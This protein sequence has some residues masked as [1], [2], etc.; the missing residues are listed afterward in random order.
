MNGTI[1]IP[2]GRRRHQSL[3]NRRPLQ[4]HGPGCRPKVEILPLFAAK[5]L[6]D[7]QNLHQY[8]P[9]Q[10]ND[11]KFQEILIDNGTRV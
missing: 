9:K 4:L 7:R 1:S 8:F 11:Y 2:N 5:Q 3:Q 10:Q 6:E